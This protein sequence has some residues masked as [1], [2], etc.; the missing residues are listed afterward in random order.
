M[1]IYEL[2]AGNLTDSTSDL[3]FSIKNIDSSELT[4]LELFTKNKNLIEYLHRHGYVTGNSL[5]AQLISCIGQRKAKELINQREQEQSQKLIADQID[6]EQSPKKFLQLQKEQKKLAIKS[7]ISAKKNALIEGLQ[8]KLYQLYERERK[9]PFNDEAQQYKFKLE[10]SFLIQE[11]IIENK[12]ISYSMLA[13]ST[14]SLLSKA[15]EIIESYKFP[16]PNLIENQTSFTIEDQAGFLSVTMLSEYYL[17][18]PYNIGRLNSNQDIV[19]FCLTLNKFYEQQNIRKINYTPLV[20]TTKKAKSSYYVL[21]IIKYITIYKIRGIFACLLIVMGI[22]YL[23]NLALILKNYYYLNLIGFGN[24]Y[25]L[26]FYAISS[27]IP[28]VNLCANIINLIKNKIRNSNSLLITVLPNKQAKPQPVE[29]PRDERI[30]LKLKD[31]CQ[32]QFLQKAYKQKPLG[33]I[34]QLP[35]VEQTV[36][37]FSQQYKKYCNWYFSYIQRNPFG[38]SVYVAVRGISLFSKTIYLPVLSKRL[39]NAYIDIDKAVDGHLQQSMILKDDIAF[40]KKSIPQKITDGE[41]TEIKKNANGTFLCF[42][43]ISGQI[44]HLKTL[45]AKQIEQLV[46]T[47]HTCQN[48]ALIIYYKTTH[49]S[50]VWKPLLDTTNLSSVTRLAVPSNLI[51]NPSRSGRI[52][53]LLNFEF[54]TSFLKQFTADIIKSLLIILLSVIIYIPLNKILLST[55]YFLIQIPTNLLERTFKVLNLTFFSDQ[56]LKFEHKLANLYHYIYFHLAY[57]FNK[58]KTYIDKK[59]INEFEIAQTV[60]TLH[61]QIT[62]YMSWLNKYK[63]SRDLLI[64]SR[65]IEMFL[66]QCNEQ[67]TSYNQEI[68]IEEIINKAKELLQDFYTSAD[69]MYQQYIRSPKTLNFSELRAKLNFVDQYIGLINLYI[70]YKETF[71]TSFISKDG[72]ISE[73]LLYKHILG[74][75]EVRSRLFILENADIEPSTLKQYISKINLLLAKCK[76][77]KADHAHNILRLLKNFNVDDKIKNQIVTPCINS[78]LKQTAKFYGEKTVGVINQVYQMFSAKSEEPTHRTPLNSPDKVKASPNRNP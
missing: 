1:P 60:A 67:A 39:I 14:S 5:V 70:S 21:N 41:Y 2:I 49:H 42:R 30:Y 50:R 48:Q 58:I 66:E 61:G 7:S 72:K 76:E 56:L 68:P 45:T 36:D 77:V 55:L 9:I 27:T 33:I 24:A 59:N 74:I 53:S 65:E 13:G 63:V 19:N 3:L 12:K 54:I 10:L 6:Q 44:F 15:I 11:Y 51:Q 64:R 46:K 73:D 8:D 34:W 17:V 37:Y 52:L 35:L 16:A 20:S 23:P 43:Y 28:I 78:Y 75:L 18:A 32:E 71:S 57:L 47:E 26:I 25:T 31:R 29:L 40:S 22:L 4:V 38:F 69:T 62:P